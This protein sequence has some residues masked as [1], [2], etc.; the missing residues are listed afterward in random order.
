MMTVNFGQPRWIDKIVAPDMVATIGKVRDELEAVT[1]ALGDLWHQYIEVLSLFPQDIATH[2]RRGHD[3][4]IGEYFNLF[5][6]R[7]VCR[8]KAGSIPLETKDTEE[9]AKLM[10]NQRTGAAKS[11]KDPESVLIPHQT[12]DRRAGHAC[13]AR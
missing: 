13:R 7:E 10:Q 4:A 6:H 3:K 9:R 8:I 1:T 12:V 2:L 11:V 5:V